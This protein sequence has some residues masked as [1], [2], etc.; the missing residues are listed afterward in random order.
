M[1]DNNGETP[2]LIS[3]LL[4]P[5]AHW[6]TSRF[7]VV[8]ETFKLLGC[9]ISVS[10]S[11]WLSQVSFLLSVPAL[12]QLPLPSSSL[13]DSPFTGR[14]RK[15]C[16]SP[17]VIVMI[18]VRVYGWSHDKMVCAWRP[19]LLTERA[20]CTNSFSENFLVASLGAWTMSLQITTI[21]I[22][23]RVSTHDHRGFVSPLVS[24]EH[25]REGIG[26]KHKPLFI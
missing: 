13:G 12:S 21:A 20:L 9:F 11:P 15:G 26:L 5:V 14:W 18:V 25:A 4:R 16:L 17:C 8:V 7:L 22:A 19:F 6:H 23:T 3:R 24:L 1:I 10:S 2:Y